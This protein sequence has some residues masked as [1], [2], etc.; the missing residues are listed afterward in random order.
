MAWSLS[1]VTAPAVEPIT[2]EEAK[3]WIKVVHS[4]EDEIISNLINVARMECERETG[5]ALITQTW[6]MQLDYWP[7]GSWLEM[8]K[9]LLQEVTSVEYL[10]AD[11][12]LVVFP[13]TSYRVDT[14]SV[15]GRLILVSSEGWPA[16][17]GEPSSIKIQFVA[18]YG[19]APADV[20]ID[21]RHGMLVR[22]GDLYDHRETLVS[23]PVGELD[24]V[25]R[26]WADRTFHF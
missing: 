21:K 10:N 13:S 1:P 25:R 12:D 11:G 19:D 4:D 2:L 14:A 22:V 8:P 7:D 5:F 6:D 17:L 15:P 18:G 16:S 9:P 26:L 24:T 23:G 3:A 20:P